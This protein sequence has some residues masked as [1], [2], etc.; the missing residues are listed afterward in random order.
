MDGAQREQIVR[1]MM[2][3]TSAAE[4]EAARKAARLW[5]D[6]FPDDR[7]VMAAGEQLVMKM[8]APST[9]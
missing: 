5:L 3:A 4:I 1:A 8:L 2:T 7:Y 6:R 9:R